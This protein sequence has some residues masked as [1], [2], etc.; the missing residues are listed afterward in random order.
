[1]FEKIVFCRRTLLIIFA[2][3][4]VSCSV[5]PL[6]PIQ[7]QQSSIPV[8]YTTDVQPI[9]NQ[10]CVSCHSCYNAACQAKFSSFEG[11]DRGA[12]KTSLYNATRLS[13][14][15]PTRLFKD[16]K[17]TEE[18]RGKGFYSLTKNEQNTAT[19][20]ADILS[21]FIDQKMKRPE[22]V[23]SYDPENESLSC[24]ADS[25]E[26]AE[27]FDDKP[28]NGMPY[29]FPA[30]QAREYNT[31]VQWISQG[32]HGPSEQEK[33]KLMT[34][35]RKIIT[36]IEMWQDF[37][38]QPDPKHVVTARY[39]YEHLYLA[40]LSFSAA[41][42]EFYELVRST[43]PTS[44]PLGKIVTARPFDDPRVSR[45]YYRLTKIHSTIVHK[46]HMVVKLDAAKLGRINEQFINTEWD[47][48]PHYIDYD[49]IASANPLNVF[50]QIPVRSR[51]QFLLDNSH[52][53]IMTF[54]R[55]PVCRGQM[56]L[57]VIHDQF[58][59]MFK[60]PEFELAIHRPHFLLRQSEN[61]TLPIAD[62]DGA[63]L[64]TFSDKYLDKYHNYVAD[65][66]AMY[67]KAYPDG[68]GYESIWKGET[69]DDAPMLTVYRH[70]NS[71]SVHK[72]LVGGMP[73]TLWVI[74]YPQFERIYYT[75]VAGFDVFGNVSH[76]TNIRRYM[77]FL[78][79]EG[80]TNFLFYMPAN[81]RLEM[82]KSWYIG[83]DE[84]QELSD[85]NILSNNKSGVDFE[86]DFTKH[87]F[88]ENLV[89]K[90]IL[91][92]TGIKFDPI[93]YIGATDPIPEMPEDIKT[94]ADIGNALKSV[95]LPNTGFLSYMHNSGL[96]TIHIRITG[97]DG[98]EYVATMVINR[99]HDNVFSLFS[100]GDSLDPSKDTIDFVKGSIGSY[101]NVFVELK[102]D[103][104]PD[105][106]QLIKN[107]N[108]SEE[109]HQ[110]ANE[111]FISRS[112]PDFWQSYDWFQAHF[113]NAEVINAGLYDLN[114]YYKTAW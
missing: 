36:E 60:D 91:P 82:F 23:G 68:F 1:M 17:N 89:N 108:D 50:S 99:W 79:M 49:N 57:N 47:E 2:L 112:D 92:E 114:R 10:R 59:V 88:V 32:A 94:K 6:P 58:W 113:N 52:Y 54:I 7:V 103:E 97:S 14:I 53:F 62:N 77:D 25:D 76:Q 83:N 51:Y 28:N 34:P 95:T 11:L 86:T 33:I 21:H 104:L 90:H 73:R 15:S 16:A 67:S 43:T 5:A 78:R 109:H 4:L 9:L 80:E 64:D 71:A 101:V 84:V 110:R 56:A 111:Y 8:H 24:P 100:E 72:G 102:A 75:L 42:D 46:T 107:F 96:N 106:L 69:A 85:K 70:F 55:G 63:L 37:L 48:T 22:V 26:L 31:L 40:H 81:E 93:N 30:L 105:F 38:N 35:S 87:E 66:A 61:L 65:K 29:G 39:L 13:A 3:T 20:N 12:T 18:W 98:T 44:E 41:P 45:V 19:Q 27:Y 74:D